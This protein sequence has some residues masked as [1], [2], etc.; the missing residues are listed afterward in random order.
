MDVQD[1]QDMDKSEA[2]Q[3]QAGDLLLYKPERYNKIPNMHELDLISED[4][5][6]NISFINREDIWLYVE[7][8]EEDSDIIYGKVAQ[9]VKEVS[10]L[11]K[12]QRVAV[13]RQHVCEVKYHD[14]HDDSD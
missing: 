13:M 5:L 4:D 6:V 12:G 2:L 11:Q 7:R 8:V 9:A 14:P 1:R 10:E 3:I